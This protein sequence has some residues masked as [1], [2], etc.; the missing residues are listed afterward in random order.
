MTLRDPAF[1][2]HTLKNLYDEATVEVVGIIDPSGDFDTE[3]NQYEVVDLEGDNYIFCVT[4]DK[5]V[6][7]GDGHGLAEDWQVQ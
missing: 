1:A 3:R 4:C 5:R 7:P 6:T 2:E